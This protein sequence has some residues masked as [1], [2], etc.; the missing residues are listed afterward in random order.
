[1]RVDPTLWEG[2]KSHSPRSKKCFHAST[3]MF[4]REG[5][6]GS[7]VRV[8]AAG[9]RGGNPVGCLPAIPAAAAAVVRNLGG[10]DCC[11]ALVSLGLLGP[12]PGAAAIAPRP[13]SLVGSGWKWHAAAAPYRLHCV[14]ISAP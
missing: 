5:G 13:C 6:G 3:V 7:G 8:D 9:G 14:C 4:A 10:V 12:P 1:M 11:A 2:C